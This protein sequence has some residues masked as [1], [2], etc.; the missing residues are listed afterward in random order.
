M[1]PIDLRSIAFAAVAAMGLHASAYS[2]DL[3]S[4]VDQARHLKQT[5]F[6]PERG[7]GTVPALPAVAKDFESCKKVFFDG[8]PPVVAGASALA[9]RPL[10]FDGFATLY[11]GV[12]KIPVF[13]A[14]VLN[15]ATLGY[16]HKQERTNFFFE[17]ARVPSKLRASLNDYKGSGFDR[18]HNFPA[19]DARTPEAMAQSFS[20]ANMMPQAPEHNRKV[21]AG[22]EEATIK[23]ARR[24]QGDV[25][26][27]TG[28]VVDASQC[29]IESVAP[30]AQSRRD[31]RSCT[32]GNGVAVPAYIYKV[33]FDPQTQRAW[34]HWSQN[35]NDQKAGKPISYAE[36]VQRTGI[37]F[38]PSASLNR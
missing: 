13:S 2:F 9:A 15:R 34:A 27:I 3:K 5:S 16:E 37:D 31:L 6:G 8:K 1:S 21:W 32:I 24:A 14:E 4:L 35:R 26:V 18:G 22:Y 19:Q 17:D 25:Y 33:V 23:Y 36:I 12:H 30:D 7:G 38:F 29:P 10:C 28:S 11:S 20:L